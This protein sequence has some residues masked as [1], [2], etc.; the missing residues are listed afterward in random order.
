M[1]LVVGIV[2]ERF[3]EMDVFMEGSVVDNEVIF[4]YLEK[5]IDVYI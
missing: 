3:I 5:L 2:D 1:L 4:F